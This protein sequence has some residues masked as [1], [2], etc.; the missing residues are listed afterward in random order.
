MR[1][2]AVLTTKRRGGSMRGQLLISCHGTSSLPVAQGENDL[3]PRRRCTARSGLLTPADF[4]WPAGS[5]PSRTGAS[6]AGPATFFSTTSERLHQHVRAGCYLCACKVRSRLKKPTVWRCD[7]PL[8][9]CLH[10][11]FHLQAPSRFSPA[12]LSESGGC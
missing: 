7:P 8:L 2:L 9:W 12:R 11:L 1:L 5:L 3:G 4:A 10:L 6:Q